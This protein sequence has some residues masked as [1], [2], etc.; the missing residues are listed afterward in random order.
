M[1]QLGRDADP[2]PLAE[3]AARADVPLRVV[4]L[5]ALPRVRELCGADLVLVRPDQHVAWRGDHV[6]D[7]EALL[8]QVTGAALATAVPN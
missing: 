5:T 6:E 2:R 3:A 4:D 1:L 8:A 7:A